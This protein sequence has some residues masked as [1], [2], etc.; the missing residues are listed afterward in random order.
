MTNTNIPYTLCPER[1]DTIPIA[2][3]APPIILFILNNFITLLN[4]Y[5]SFLCSVSFQSLIKQYQHYT[6]KHRCKVKQG[7]YRLS[8][9]ELMINNISA[10]N[11]K[12]TILMI[13]VQNTPTHKNTINNSFITSN[14]FKAHYSPVI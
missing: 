8:L 14:R 12:A 9:Q 11:I 13:P 4:H 7:I 6:H 1:Q 2:R 3:Q 10:A 5:S